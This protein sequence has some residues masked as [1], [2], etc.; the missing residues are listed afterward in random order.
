M[1]G[2][3]GAHIDGV[4]ADLHELEFFEDAGDLG[5]AARQAI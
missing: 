4:E 3:D 1:H 2:A 5:E